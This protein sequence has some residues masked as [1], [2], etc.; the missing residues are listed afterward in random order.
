MPGRP[1]I[2]IVDDRPHGLN[3]LR[4]A[5]DRRYSNDYRTIAHI[6]AR[7]ALDDLAKLKR[8]GERIALVIADQWMPEMQGR[9]VLRRVQ[10]L[11]PEAQRALLVGWGDARAADMLLQGCALKELH[12][13]LLKPWT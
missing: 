4:D 8:D 2:L 13:Y 3:A 6:S 1:V 9:E 11:H 12:N 5:I 10:A 7:A